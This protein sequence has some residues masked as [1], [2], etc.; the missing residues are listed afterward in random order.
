MSASKKH[1]VFRFYGSLN[2][3]MSTDERQSDVP[4]GFWGR[5]ALNDA[6]WRCISCDTVYWEGS[7]VDRM[8]ERIRRALGRGPTKSKCLV[9]LGSINRDHNHDDLA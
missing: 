5:P 8:R 2:D 1:A 4:Y 3:F 9:L 6:F 7:H